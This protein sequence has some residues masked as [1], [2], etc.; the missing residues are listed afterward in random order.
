MITTLT[1]L[2]SNACLIRNS[3]LNIFIITRFVPLLQ[4]CRAWINIRG[5]SSMWY[6]LS[7]WLFSRSLLSKLKRVIRKFLWG[8][9]DFKNVRPK[10]AWKTIIAPTSEGGLG[11]VDPLMQC[12]ALLAKFIVRRLLP[13]NELWKMLLQLRMKEVFPKTRCWRIYVGEENQIKLGSS[14]NFIFCLIV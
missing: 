1:L 4:D 10:V 14:G 5:H 3:S 8:S 6:I 9:T 2:W 13:G 7:S 12:K 11:L